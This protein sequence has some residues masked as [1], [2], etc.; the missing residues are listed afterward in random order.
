MYGTEDSN[1]KKYML[2]QGIGRNTSPNSY[3]GLQIKEGR[4]KPRFM[5][6]REIDSITKKRKAFNALY[7]WPIDNVL[8]VMARN[9]KIDGIYLNGRQGWHFTDI[10]RE[11]IQTK[12]KLEWRPRYEKF[13]EFKNDLEMIRDYRLYH[14]CK[15][16]I[17]DEN[18]QLLNDMSKDEWTMN[19]MDRY[20]PLKQLWH[21][22]RSNIIKVKNL[23][24]R[25][26]E[27]NIA[28]STVEI[29]I[30][31]D[32][33]EVE[34]LNNK[35][36]PTQLRI[37]ENRWAKEEKT[38]TI[39]TKKRKFS[40]SRKRKL[41]TDKVRIGSE[42]IL[43]ELKTL[44]KL[45]L[46]MKEYEGK[47]ESN[48]CTLDKMDQIREIE[49]SIFDEE[50][51]ER[52]IQIILS[53]QE[54]TD[55]KYKILEEELLSGKN[56]LIQM[57]KI[58][59]L[60]TNLLG[61]VAE[62]ENNQIEQWEDITLENRLQ[63]I[64]GNRIKSVF[65]HHIH[66]I[67]KL[68]V[69]FRKEIELANELKEMCDSKEGFDLLLFKDMLRSTIENKEYE[70]IKFQF[71][72]RW[73]VEIEENIAKGMK[74]PATKPDKMSTPIGKELVPLQSNLVQKKKR[75]IISSDENS[76]EHLPST[77][78]IQ[79]NQSKTKNPVVD[80][81]KNAIVISSEEKTSEEGKSP[82]V[83]REN[84]YEFI[85]YESSDDEQEPENVKKL[86]EYDTSDSE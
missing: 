65:N 17:T 46:S 53:R 16:D 49:R 12:H 79:S 32:E 24:F 5:S 48:M 34:P 19:S 59:T 27:D 43:Q 39:P 21:K 40:N 36:N 11:E 56:Y 74:K 6:L 35:I 29:P 30:I 18:L 8:E 9:G 71:L 78:G 83:R 7:F 33:D 72:E 55:L 10:R 14:A 63:I 22:Y 82:L 1:F 15:N 76:D 50:T 75:F 45:I 67:V 20:V 47:D 41:K 13:Q 73:C 37:I 54:R 60:R 51:K 26:L 25:L 42:E 23:E 64:T 80:S 66:P 38:T 31:I 58:E 84:E 69:E 81:P 70:G 28:N 3:I 44:N 85:T 62:I 86:L 77:S 61:M 52:M 57:P 2:W 68:L 4:E